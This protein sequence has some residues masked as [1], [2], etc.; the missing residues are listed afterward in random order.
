[1]GAIKKE[2]EKLYDY[3]YLTK[4]YFQNDPNELYNFYLDFRIRYDKGIN[5][6]KRLNNLMKY[7]DEDI[8]K[9]IDEFL[10]NVKDR[11]KTNLSSTTQNSRIKKCQSAKKSF[12]N[13]IKNTYKKTSYQNIV[14]NLYP[15][16][17]QKKNENIRNCDLTFDEFFKK[18]VISYY[19]KNKKFTND[20][21][22]LVEHY[23]D[24]PNKED[25]NMEWENGERDFVENIELF[26][27]DSEMV[28]RLSNIYE[29]K[30]KLRTYHPTIL[31]DYWQHFM[32]KEDKYLKGLY[33]YNN[34]DFYS[35][36]EKIY[37]QKEDQKKFDKDNLYDEERNRQI[38]MKKDRQNHI[39]ETEE[40]REKLI[41]ELA[42][43]KD[44]YKTG[45]VMLELKKQFKYDNVIKKMIKN[46][47]KDNKLFKFPEEYAI[48]DEEEE[49]DT[50]LNMI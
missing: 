15:K 25:K 21:N 45:R 19:K 2:V 9:C 33:K 28:T 1:M 17:L 12:D 35:L 46:E 32:S 20:I 36:L 16:S 3:Y 48:R 22:E 6:P 5:I 42:Q 18:I 34:D 39:R 29:K 43:P 38:Q 24:L 41:N 44:K 13:T 8:D 14:N 37:L 40:E 23:K 11:F 4:G 47:F 7:R 26:L 30:T 31:H 27:N 49:K 10:K 50:F